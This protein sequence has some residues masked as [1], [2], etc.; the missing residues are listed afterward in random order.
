MQR[1]EFLASIIGG[2]AA[3]FGVK[4]EPDVWD[5]LTMSMKNPYTG[6]LTSLK[7][8]CYGRNARYR[9]VKCVRNVAGV[10]LIPKGSFEKCD[11]FTVRIEGHRHA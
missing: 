10:S 6:K 5:V 2:I 8:L 9:N 7:E 1:R 11:M 4:R 3:C